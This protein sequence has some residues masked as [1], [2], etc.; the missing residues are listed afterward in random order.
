MG[1][2]RRDSKALPEDESGA[3]HSSGDAGKEEIGEFQGDFT[4]FRVYFKVVNFQTGFRVL[5]FLA[6]RVLGFWGFSV[7]GVGF[8]V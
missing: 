2:L 7:Q 4:G 1:S 3:E 8:W 5:G 6:G